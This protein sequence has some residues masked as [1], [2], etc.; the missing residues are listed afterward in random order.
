MQAVEAAFQFHHREILAI[1]LSLA[2]LSYA[3]RKTEELGIESVKYMQAD[4]LDLHKLDRQFDLIECAGVL[5][6]MENP[7]AG[8]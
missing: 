2:S 5:H 8:W 7:V 1:D 3:K 4:I 6:H